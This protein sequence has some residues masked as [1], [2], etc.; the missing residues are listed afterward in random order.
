MLTVA[1]LRAR[2]TRRALH[3]V[4]GKNAFGEVKLNLL[5]CLNSVYVADRSVS[6]ATT[7]REHSK[8]KHVVSGM[9]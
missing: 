7:G 5:G 1:Q 8:V 2:E 6:S 9:F 4:R 3:Y